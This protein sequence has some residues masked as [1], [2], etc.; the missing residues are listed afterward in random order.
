MAKVTIWEETTKHPISLIGKAAGT[1]WGADTTDEEKNYKRGWDCIKSQ[2]GRTWEWPDVYL[3]LDHW[4]ARVIREYYT[5]IGGAPSRL[6][7]STRYV[8]CT[9]FKYV[10]PASIKNCEHPRA[11]ALYHDLMS[12][13]S[14]TITELEEL[15]IPREDSAM[16]LPLAMETKVVVKANLRH[17]IDMAHQRLCVRAYWEYR[18]LM[19]AI[20]NA[21]ADYS[22]EWETLVCELFEPKCK[23]LGYCPEKH[24]C[25]RF[26]QKS[27]N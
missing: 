14:Y 18:E 7:E 27:N 16:C 25:G 6:Q 3:V 21:L 9:N 11:L 22:I 2:H 24:S 15:G 26:A 13:I 20:K 8:D 1:C 19:I 4:S 5:H 10:T 17:L 23:Y 12:A